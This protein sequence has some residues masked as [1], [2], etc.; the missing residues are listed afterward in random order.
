MLAWVFRRCDDEAEAVET[1][2]GLV[3]ALEAVLDTEGLDISARRPGGAAAVD[4]EDWRAELPQVHEHF[5]TFGDRLPEQLREQ[6]DALEKRLN[7]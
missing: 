3:P 5:A 1:P 2:I 7:A 6:L 4:P